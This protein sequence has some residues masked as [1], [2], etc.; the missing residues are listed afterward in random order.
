M[1][2]LILSLCILPCAISYPAYASMFST[3][4]LTSSSYTFKDAVIDAS[5]GIIFAL[6]S[7]KSDNKYYVVAYN[8]SSGTPTFLSANKDPFPTTVYN[9]I[10]I[11][12]QYLLVCNNLYQVYA[13]NSTDGS[14]IT[15]LNIQ[16]MYY[17]RYLQS[18]NKYVYSTYANLTLNITYSIYSI[19]LG[20]LSSIPVLIVSPV[21]IYT[22]IFFS[23]S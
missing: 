21:G 11:A 18:Q 12:G 6:G 9:S 3:S 2:L 20:N 7:S 8:F 17:G 22:Y 10:D 1:I 5:G 4:G 23:K 14:Y 13:F 15:I 19:D 16:M